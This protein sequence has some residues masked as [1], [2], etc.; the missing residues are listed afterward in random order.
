[1]LSMELFLISTLALKHLFVSELSE[2]AC[3]DV[4][5]FDSDFDDAEYD[6]DNV[7]STEFDSLNVVPIDFDVI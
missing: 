5:D 4:F 7:E 3:I 2:F 6:V 1:M